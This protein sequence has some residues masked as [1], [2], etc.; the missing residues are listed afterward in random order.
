MAGETD[1]VNEGN[2]TEGDGYVFDEVLLRLLLE[3]G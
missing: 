1:E 2:D 3:S